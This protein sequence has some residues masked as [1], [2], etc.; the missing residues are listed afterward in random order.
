MQGSLRAVVDW[1]YDLPLGEG[2]EGLATLVHLKDGDGE[3][4]ETKE[5]AWP[6]NSLELELSPSIPWQ[7]GSASKLRS[8]TLPWES[9]T[10]ILS[11]VSN[12]RL[13]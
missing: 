11:R 10:L 5:V 3:L 4:V 2:F 12:M 9:L 1:Q 6:D 13:W 7:P 8:W